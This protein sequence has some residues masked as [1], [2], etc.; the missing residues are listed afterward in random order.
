MYRLKNDSPIKSMISGVGVKTQ[1]IDNQLHTLNK[2]GYNPRKHWK[3][4]IEIHAE[5]Q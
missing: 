2:S 1:L 5:Y 4:N 3:N